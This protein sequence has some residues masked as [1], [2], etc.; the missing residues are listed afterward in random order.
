MLN[1]QVIARPAEADGSPSTRLG[2]VQEIE[3]KLLA[4]PAALGSLHE[5]PAIQ[6]YTSTMSTARRLE[7][8]YYD[9]PDKALFRQGLTLRVR[10]HGRRYVQTLKRGPVPEKL[11]VREEWETS[12]DSIVPN[13]S[14]LSASGINPL[15]DEIAHG[16]LNPIFV[17]KVRRR[18]RCLELAGTQVEVAFDEGSIEVGDR[19]VPLSEVE[20]EVK[21]G[22]ARALYDLGIDLIETTPL[23]VC[24]RSKA[25][26]GYELA[27]GSAPKAV[28]AAAPILTPACTVDDI[29]AALLGSCQH[30]VL[31]NQA[32][33]EAEHDPEG[34]HQMRVA[35]R[36][37]RTAST[38]LSRDLGS[39]T[40]RTVSEDANWLA[41]LLGEAR[42]W[43][44]FIT[45]T[46]KGPSEALGTSIDFD[47][48]RRAAEPHRLMAY[49]TLREAFAGKRYNR[50]Q[51]S[52]LRW[53]AA[54]GWRNE[55][56]SLPLATLLEPGSA[57]AMR[58]L[59][60]LH[61]QAIRRGKQ[62][63]YLPPEARHR[64]RIAL[65][66][67]RYALE[68][69]AGLFELNGEW[70]DYTRILAKLQDALGRENDAATTLPRLVTVARNAAAPEVERCIG[71]VIG[72]QA[73]DSIE[74]GRKLRAHWRQ[75][76]T[77]QPV[78]AK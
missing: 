24:I 36:R 60:R 31:A 16:T 13:L 77:M 74:N 1:E 34:V 53:I 15:F 27:F 46:L 50:F 8:V 76:K 57:F 5:A 22:D 51:L 64:L 32:V 69:F 45:D 78:W 18:T 58:V 59:D 62:F 48:L 26:R 43:D 19:C 10:R 42:D 20:L 21:S 12:V 63:Q 56:A 72:W 55:L 23:R 61:H 11:F 38:L 70:E 33:A 71:A 4:S 40:L 41:Q 65:K 49:A 66:K 52:L 29:I 28:K 75:F 44:V 2:P 30:Q 3:L 17:T 9:T 35:L 39:P 68:F 67:L 73:R 7:A 47:V 6:R 25:D 14:L 54:R 37:L